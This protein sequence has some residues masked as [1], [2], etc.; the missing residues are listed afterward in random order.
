MAAYVAPEGCKGWWR[1]LRQVHRRRP[2]TQCWIGTDRN[3]SIAGDRHRPR[4]HATGDGRAVRV[5]TVDLH[6]RRRDVEDPDEARVAAAVDDVR[7]GVGR[8]RLLGTGL[9]QHDPSVLV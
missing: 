1:S 3:S 2:F 4:D 5:A 8:R 6:V 7:A 9:E